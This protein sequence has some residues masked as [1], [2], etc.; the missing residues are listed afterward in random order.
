MNCRY[1]GDKLPGKQSSCR[2]RDKFFDYHHRTVLGSDKWQET[3]QR[4]FTERGA[5]CERCE[6]A[7]TLEVHHVN[8]CRLGDERLSDLKVLCAKCHEWTHLQIIV[9]K[10]R[11]RA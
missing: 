4:L 11:L 10:H 7:S 1:C 8:Y 5:K 2:G 9:Q 6:E 3:K